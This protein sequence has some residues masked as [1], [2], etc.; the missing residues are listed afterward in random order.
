MGGVRL[1]LGSDALRGAYAKL[2]W[3]TTRHEEMERIFEEYAKPEG[4]DERPLGIRFRQRDRPAGWIVAFFIAEE[5]MPIELSLLAADLVHNTRTALDYVLARLKERFGGNPGKGYFPTWATEEEWKQNVVE[6]GKG[7]SLHGLDSS[8]VDLIYAAQPLHRPEPA[9]DPLVTLNTLDN[10]DKHRLLQPT[11]VYPGVERGIDLIEERDSKAIKI[12]RN[13]WTSG[14]PIKHGTDVALFMVGGRGM[15]VVGVSRDAKLGFATGEVGAPRIG[16]MDMIERVRTIR[17]P[18]GRSTGRRSSPCAARRSWPGRIEKSLIATSTLRRLGI[19]PA[20]SRGRA[21]QS[22]IQKRA[23]AFPPR[24]PS[25]SRT[26]R[27]CW[28]SI[29]G[30]RSGSDDWSGA[31]SKRAMRGRPPSAAKT[32]SCPTGASTG[33]RTASEKDRH[34]LVMRPAAAAPP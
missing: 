23:A 16:Y 13:L 29:S 19:E 25:L 24:L 15:D 17:P 30:I 2:D 18:T 31:S 28:P 3:A 33:R 34:G 27:H 9:A 22:V 7:S 11:F 1:S 4:G 20:K 6:R 26:P 5:P 32:R 8:A 12:K 14:Q 10:A 21:I